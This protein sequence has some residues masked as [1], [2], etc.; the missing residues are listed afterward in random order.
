MDRKTVLTRHF[1]STCPTQCLVEQII[2]D[3]SI[4]THLFTFSQSDILFLLF[5]GQ[6][7]LDIQD[8]A[9]MSLLL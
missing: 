1:G 7:L 6:V 4:Q 3:I 9:Q 2:T 8:L 5:S